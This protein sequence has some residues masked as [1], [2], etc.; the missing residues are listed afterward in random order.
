MSGSEWGGRRVTEARAFMAQTLPAPCGLCSHTVEPGDRW[1]IGHKIS[2][3]ERPDLTWVP[4]NWR[5]EHR[6]CSDKTGQAGVIAKAKADA[7]RGL[8]PG[9][10]PPGQQIGRA[11]V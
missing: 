1:V 2:R 3:G 4:S 10:T 6:S 8:F 5:V 11:H 9:E 7:M